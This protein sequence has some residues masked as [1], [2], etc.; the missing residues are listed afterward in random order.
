MRAPNLPCFDRSMRA[1]LVCSARNSLSNSHAMIG[2]FLAHCEAEGHGGLLTNGGETSMRPLIAIAASVAMLVAQ[3]PLVPARA[4][5][6]PPA[7]QVVSNNSVI[8]QT[9]KAFPNGGGALSK[10]ITA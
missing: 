4:D 5:T 10:D 8:A 1:K 2:R 7:P 6:A 3:I 9:F